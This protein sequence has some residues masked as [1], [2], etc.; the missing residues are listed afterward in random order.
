VHSAHRGTANHTIMLGPD[1]VELLGVL[2]PRTRMR[3][4]GRCW[5][6]ARGS[7]GRG[8]G[9]GTPKRRQST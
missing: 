9:P 3:Q 1:Y 4:A 7:N 2:T 6:S 5:Q 8:S